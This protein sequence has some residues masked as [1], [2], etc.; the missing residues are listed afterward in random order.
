M[1]A[2]GFRKGSFYILQVQTV[3]HSSWPFFQL[4]KHKWDVCIFVYEDIILSLLLNYYTIAFFFLFLKCYIWKF[5][6]W[7]SNQS[8]VH[9]HHSHSN[10]RS[11]PGLQLALQLTA[12]PVLNPLSEAKDWNC[13]LMYTSWVNFHWATTGIFHTDTNYVWKY[14]WDIY[15]HH[16]D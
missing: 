8:T 1:R 15:I 16:K 9:L 12:M 2:L 5:L 7:D 11:E 13:T 10:T 6:G 14:A 3:K 4:L